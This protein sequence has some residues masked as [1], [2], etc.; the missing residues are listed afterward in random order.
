[1]LTHLNP[2]S[3][4]YMCPSVHSG[5][6]EWVFLFHL[7]LDMLS[8]S[9]YVAC[10]RCRQ[11]TTVQQVDHIIQFY[12]AMQLEAMIMREPCAHFADQYA[13]YFYLSRE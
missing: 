10:V 8:T 1:M 5:G 7:A 9:A 13:N 12:F 11:E 3:T 2:T 6:I 4:H